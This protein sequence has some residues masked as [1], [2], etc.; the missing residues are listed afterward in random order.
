M[1][2]GIGA[3]YAGRPDPLRGPGVPSTTGEAI[4][5]IER[6]EEGKKNRIVTGRDRSVRWIT[7][8]PVEP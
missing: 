5:G 3:V 4:G 7:Y 2:V 8:R 1:E 6:P